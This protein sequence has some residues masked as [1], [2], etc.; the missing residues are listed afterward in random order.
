MRISKM[1][2]RGVR[3]PLRHPEMAL[4]S[5]KANRNALLIWMHMDNGVSGVGRGRYRRP[6][7]PAGHR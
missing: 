7:A 1:E 2:W 6:G 5:T 4:D 3:V